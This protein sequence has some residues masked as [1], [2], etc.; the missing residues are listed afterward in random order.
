MSISGYVYLIQAVGT[1]RYKIGR[2]IDPNKRI[3][4]LGQQSAF[5]LKLLGTLYTDDFILQEKRLHNVAAHY[6]IH[7][8]WFELPESWLISLK[9]WFYN[10]EC[11][12]YRQK[13]IPGNLLVLVETR[14]FSE[15]LIK[16][17]SSE[18]T[19]EEEIK[20]AIT[21]LGAVEKG[22]KLTKKV[23]KEL[24]TI[25]GNYPSTQSQAR[26]WKA[27]LQEISRELQARIR[28]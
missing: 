8:E 5:P 13:A 15:P 18:Q 26:L 27:R 7:G 3:E 19:T 28:Y 14:G 12:K 2:A 22:V 24:F 10:P 6:R 20:R 21:L 11:Q 23:R 4:R 1:N 25:L 9:D 17:F 16:H